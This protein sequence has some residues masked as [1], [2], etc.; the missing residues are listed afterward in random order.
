MSSH[1]LWDNIVGNSVKSL[2]KAQANNIRSLSLIVYTGYDVC[3]GIQD[4]G[5]NRHLE[6]MD[7]TIPEMKKGSGFTKS[8]CM[9]NY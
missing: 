3:E 5:D 9:V 2:T 6:A 1:S 7:Q 8:S 4:C